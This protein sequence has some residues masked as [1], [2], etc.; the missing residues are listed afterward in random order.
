M[1]RI[2]FIPAHFLRVSNPLEVLVAVI[3]PPPHAEGGGGVLKLGN[4]GA[5]NIPLAPKGVMECSGE[6]DA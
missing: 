2:C 1:V 6:Q 3:V 5:P 4:F